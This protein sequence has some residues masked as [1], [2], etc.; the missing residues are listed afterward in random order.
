MENMELRVLESSISAHSD[1]EM[2]VEGL[3]NKTESWSHELGLRKKF[4]EKVSKGTFQRAL[5]GGERIDFLG[6]HN[7]NLLLATTEND[8]L[9]L[10]ED[11][12]GLK[13]RAR[14][15][16]TSYGKDFYVLMKDGL[17]NHMSFG[18]KVLSDKWKKLTDGTYERTIDKIALKEVS[19]VRNPA[20]PQ[21][22]ISARGIE[23]IEDVEIPAEVDE[24]RSQEQTEL[25]KVKEVVNQLQNTIDSLVKSQLEQKPEV[26][27]VK[28]EEVQIEKND[29][30]E[31][32]AETDEAKAEEVK[33]EE[34]VVETPAEPEVVAEEVVE[35]VKPEEPVVEEVKNEDVV[36]VLKKYM[37][38]QKLK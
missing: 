24:V 6:E 35:E 12:E 8:S 7:A 11:E 36:G 31:V 21:S 17:V 2:I 30:E 23:L 1:G 13:M 26:T 25:D 19:V 34:P 14:I 28:V 37:E 29:T 5:A 15:S 16:P 18:F 22:S 9:Q 20:Y 10:W 4:R 32:V 27:D 3:V 38:L 33:P